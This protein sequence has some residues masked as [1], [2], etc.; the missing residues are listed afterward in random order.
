MYLH[1]AL[2]S[3][4]HD[5]QRIIRAA[6]LAVDA[7][8][9]NRA[10]ATYCAQL[11]LFFGFLANRLERRQDFVPIFIALFHKIN[12]PLMLLAIRMPRLSAETLR[13]GSGNQ[14][15]PA[16]RHVYSLRE[17]P[18]ANNVLRGDLAVRV[19][20]GNVLGDWLAVVRV[21]NSVGGDDLPISREDR[22]D[23]PHESALTVERLHRPSSFSPLVT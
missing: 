17:Q 13:R 9:M 1:V 4:T 7:I 11:L 2:C 12:F 21:V 14:I 16:T 20:D 6:F 19:T 15:E 8:I 23:F 10:A 22:G 3:W 5:A 18:S